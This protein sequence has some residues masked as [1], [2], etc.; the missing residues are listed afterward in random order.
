MIKIVLMDID[1]V[2]TDG[3]VTV[4]SAGNEFKTLDFRDIDAVF[5]MKRRGLNVGLLT[6]ENSAIIGYFR[7]RFE[8]D[9]FYSGCKDKHAALE[10]ILAQTGASPDEVCYMGDGQY[11][12]PVMKRVKFAAC[13]SNAIPAVRRVSRIV[14]EKRG[15][16]GCIWELLEWIMEQNRNASE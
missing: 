11:D 5:E 14:F 10:E 3:K 6:G 8:P 9:F 12:I 16:D 7:K 2:L 15:G 13:P 4:D 1:G